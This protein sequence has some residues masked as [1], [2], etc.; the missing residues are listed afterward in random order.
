M[1]LFDKLFKRNEVDGNEVER[2]E[3]ERSEVDP[4]SETNVAKIWDV[5]IYTERLA[6]ILESSYKDFLMT[7]T[8]SIMNCETATDLYS[9]LD[10]AKKVEAEIV[11]DKD[12]ESQKKLKEYREFV[13]SP[14]GEKGNKKGVTSRN[15]SCHAKTAC[16]AEGSK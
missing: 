2:S 5:S 3:V 1:G 9:I 8:D 12:P 16:L 11:A 15:T 6:N 14:S 10:V 13:T 4:L 7:V